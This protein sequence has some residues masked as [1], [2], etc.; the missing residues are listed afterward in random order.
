MVNQKRKRRSKK[1]ESSKEVVETIPEA[2][3]TN[4]KDNVEKNVDDKADMTDMKAKPGASGSSREVDKA[5]AVVSSN[6]KV[7]KEDKN[8]TNGDAIALKA[9]PVNTNATNKMDESKKQ[10]ASAIDETLRVMDS[11]VDNPGPETMSKEAIGL[12][13]DGG[14]EQVVVPTKVDTKKPTFGFKINKTGFVSKLNMYVSERDQYIYFLYDGPQIKAWDTIDYGFTDAKIALVFEIQKL[15][16]TGIF[17]DFPDVKDGEFKTQYLAGSAIGFDLMS[18]LS[19]KLTTASTQQIWDMIPSLQITDI[20]S[21]NGA[22]MRNVKG[23][24]LPIEKTLQEAYANIEFRFNRNPQD[25]NDYLIVLNSERRAKLPFKLGTFDKRYNFMNF[26]GKMDVFQWMYMRLPA[27]A[28][29][30]GT[31]GND[32]IVDAHMNA[33]LSSLKTHVPVEIVDVT[34]ASNAAAVQMMSLVG[35]SDFGN[36]FRE[37]I[38]RTS[39]EKWFYQTLALAVDNRRCGIDIHFDLSKFDPTV[40]VECIAL[41]LTCHYHHLTL[42]AVNMVDGYLA[43]WLL[44]ALGKSGPVKISDGYIAPTQMDIQDNPERNFLTEAFDSGDIHG[45]LSKFKPF[46]YTD[47]IGGGWAGSGQTLLGLPE[48]IAQSTFQNGRPNNQWFIPLGGRLTTDPDVA[49]FQFELFLMLRAWS[50][51]HLKFQT[52]QKIMKT[53]FDGLM[54]NI[55]SAGNHLGELFFHMNR[56]LAEISVLPLYGQC[57]MPEQYRIYS[58]THHDETRLR[59]TLDKQSGYSALALVDPDSLGVGFYGIDAM[60]EG[61]AVHQWFQDLCEYRVLVDQL[62]RTTSQGYRNVH[63]TRT[64]RVM[65]A[66]KQAGPMEPYSS[67]LEKKFGV[68]D[69]AKRTTFPPE[70]II[71]KVEDGQN[72]IVEKYNL[73]LE[74]VDAMA[75]HLGFQERFFFDPWPRVEERNNPFGIEWKTDTTREIIKKF[76]YDD[77]ASPIVF[78]NDYPPLMRQARVEQKRIEFEIPVKVER[79]KIDAW[80]SPDQ[81]LKSPLTEIF[82]MDGESG[83]VDAGLRIATINW[84]WRW[85]DIFYNDFI[86][87]AEF[88][89]DPVWHAD[90]SAFY[91]L[92]FEELPELIQDTNIWRKSF[93]EFDS[94]KFGFVSLGV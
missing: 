77:L 23:M 55:A 36:A 74:F 35:R 49:T 64:K 67:T 16:D 34:Q 60:L 69:F 63:W 3:Q 12:N 57:L 32:A 30:D 83:N 31:A 8:L 22:S 87:N 81:V 41:K 9:E 18:L 54:D 90:T 85:T 11:V 58:E 2:D 84:Y 39:A 71:G 62:Y 46:M 56:A 93:S 76:T 48:S 50:S 45:D 75:P 70:D 52:R 6:D 4:A 66:L 78:R 21:V 37:R 13:K 17:V 38:S 26:R 72:I 59:L 24:Q 68:Q 10:A 15:Y 65:W 5:A 25:F 88:T 92:T 51:V 79:V 20:I 89:F 40:L 29:P 80:P 7:E 47:G 33:I 61:Y 73:A 28:D 53:Q 43:A 94:S 19:Q 42:T 14:A 86:R 27:D 1:K 82:R 44:P 91:P